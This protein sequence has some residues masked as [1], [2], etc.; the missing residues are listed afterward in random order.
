MIMETMYVRNVKN[1]HEETVHYAWKVRMLDTT[2]TSLKDALP[3]LV[4]DSGGVVMEVI[5]NV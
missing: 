2:T 3:F 5:E 1:P 4:A